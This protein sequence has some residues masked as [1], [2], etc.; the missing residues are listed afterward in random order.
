MKIWIHTSDPGGGAVQKTMFVSGAGSTELGAIEDG[1][2]FA[3][4]NPDNQTA[5]MCVRY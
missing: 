2:A 1:T 4:G 5:Y 3:A